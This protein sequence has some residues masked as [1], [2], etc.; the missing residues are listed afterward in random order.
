MNMFETLLSRRFIVKDQDKDLYYRAKD[1][2]GELKKFFMEKLG[3]PIIVNPYLI[4]LE[5]IPAVPQIWM[6]I[7]EFTDRIQYVFLCLVLMYLED[8]EAGEQFILSELTEFIQMN[9][10]QESIDWTLFQYRKHLVKVV[11]VCEDYGLIK[12]NDGSKEQFMSDYEQEVLY[13][14]IGSSRYFMRNFSQNVLAFKTAADFGKSEWIDLDEERGVIRRQRVYRKLLTTMGMY[15]EGE[16]DEDFAY[17]KNFRSVISHD[18]ETHLDCQLDVYKTSAFLI[19]GEHSGMGKTLPANGTIS[20]IVLL[21]NRVITD[22]VK[23][24]DLVPDAQENIYLD[25]NHFRQLVAEC[26]ER[27]GKNL[28]K[29]YREKTGGEF[30]REVR[31][32]MEEWALIQRA[33]SENMLLIRPVSGRLVGVYPKGFDEGVAVNEQQMA[34]S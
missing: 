2:V 19:L 22:H 20:D 31:Q 15:K 10:Q 32:V 8:K 11:R 26:R 5:K 16:E 25:E 7:T 18:L 17:L 4:K 3:Y 1:E 12:L 6:G 13:E 23:A 30:Y 14:N 34:D 9:N 27:F 21:L 29:S 28:T 33:G 24:G